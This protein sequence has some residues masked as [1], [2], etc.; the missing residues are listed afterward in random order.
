MTDRFVL[1]GLSQSV[2]PKRFSNPRSVFDWFLERSLGLLCALKNYKESG[3]IP[4]EKSEF[5]CKQCRLGP[6]LVGGFF[7]LS[8]FLTL[9]PTN[10]HRGLFPSLY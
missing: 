5:P 10:R 9:V 4:N 3:D 7:L 1:Y 2:C 8:S 6:K